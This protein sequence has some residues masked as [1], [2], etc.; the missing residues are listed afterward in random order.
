MPGQDPNFPKWEGCSNRCN[1]DTGHFLEAIGSLGLV[2]AGW[3]PPWPSTYP[4]W[5]I[6][7]LFSI[8]DLARRRLQD[9]F[10][11]LHILAGSTN[12]Q[13]ASL[14]DIPTLDHMFGLYGSH[15]I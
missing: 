9:I 8:F 10:G 14:A 3:I 7:D 4:V 11:F 1:K 12:A 15:A 2:I 6:K 13:K 5:T